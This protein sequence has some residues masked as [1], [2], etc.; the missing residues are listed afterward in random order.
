M[1]TN[2]KHNSKSTQ[3]HDGLGH[4]MQSA[5]WLA[6]P[7]F[8]GSTATSACLQVQN[9][10]KKRTASRRNLQNIGTFN[11]QGLLSKTKQMLLADD[12]L[13]Y[14]MKALMIQET[15]MQGNGLI[16][17]KSTEGNTVRLYYSGHN[18]KSTQGVGI[19]VHPNTKCEFLPVSSRIMMLT[20]KN[21]EVVT[22]L[23]SAYAPTNGKTIDN[24]EKTAQFYN[25]LSSIINKTRQK[26]AL[27]IGGDF[28][29]KTKQ[30]G[31]KTS[32]STAIGKFSKSKI[33]ENGELLI[34][35]AEMNDLKI[36]NTFFKHKPAHTSTWQCPQRREEI[37]DANSGT[38]RRNPYRN[39]IDYILT[40][41]SNNLKVFNSR[42]YGGFTCNSDHKP[43]IAK[44]QLKWKTSTNKKHKTKINCR[45]INKTKESLKQYQDLVRQ[46]MKQ[47]KANNIQEK[48]DNIKKKYT[49][50]SNRSG[51][52]RTKAKTH[53]Y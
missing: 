14:N 30:D 52:L 35:F 45:E 46:K 7:D 41:K 49:G 1:K 12:F 23:I 50:C 17:I 34:E 47:K 16:D 40:R 27:I 53:T 39:Q 32:G 36:T 9:K 3:H 20:I 38:T 33:N 29:A 24:P 6:P 2:N 4:Q 28:N 31:Q 19:M 18:K 42:S 8:Q 21:E 13:K 10:N 48:W 37:L 51:W 5:G 43:V 26:A 15:H 44:I 25:K 11:A 22:N